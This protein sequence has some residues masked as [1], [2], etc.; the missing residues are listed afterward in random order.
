MPRVLVSAPLAARSLWITT[1]RVGGS[2]RTGPRLKTGKLA[3]G[4]GG[5]IIFQE[6][7]MQHPMAIRA[8]LATHLSPEG[9]KKLRDY[10]KAI[11][12][13]LPGR[14]L[15]GFEIVRCMKFP[16]KNPTDQEISQMEN[17]WQ[18]N[19]R[20]QLWPGQQFESN[21]PEVIALSKLEEIWAW[22]D[23]AINQFVK[24]V[25]SPIEPQQIN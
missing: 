11:F 20:E 13:D 3:Y 12:K 10:E 23:W 16:P 14:Y 18:K 25:S 7:T 1:K 8:I 22:E 5:R 2:L 17:L 19:E 21:H 6:E 24:W 4:H 9:R 15:Q